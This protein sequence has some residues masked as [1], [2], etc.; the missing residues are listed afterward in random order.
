MSEARLAG[1]LNRGG[2]FLRLVTFGIP[3]VLGMFFH[4]LFNLVDLIIVGPLG[5]WALAGV[6]QAGIVN[7]IPMLI[8]TGV[9]NASIAY[10]SRNF[11]MRNYR[12]A[13]AYALQSFLL[14][15]VLAGALGWPSYAYAAE[16][17]RLVGSEG[18]ALGA[19]TTY[20]EIN[21]A[22]LVTMFVLMQV[23]AVLRAGGNARWP[24]ILLVGSNLL[25]VG[26][27]YAMVYGVWGFPRMEVAGAAWGTVIARGLF[28][29]LGLYIILLPGVPVRLILRR[30]WPRARM[31]GQLAGLGV[32][33]SLQ[34]VVRVCAYGA[35]LKLVNQF[36]ETEAVQ[37]ALAVGLRLDM[38]GIFTG[39]GWGAAAAAMVGQGLG[40]GFPG[41]AERAGWMASLLNV[42]LMAAIGVL[43]WWN[44]E[45]LVTFF[46]E[47]PGRDPQFAGT[48]R[49]GV[50]YLRIA[51]FG[52]P[53]AAVGITLAQSLNGAGSTK[54]P[55][56]LDAVG[57]LGLQVPVAGYIAHHHERLGLGRSAMWWSLVATTALAAAFYAYVWRRGH[58][59]HKRI[60]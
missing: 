34:F 33:S 16:L 51:V 10:M 13:N 60:S 1:D 6:N 45:W 2:L 25:N 15:L 21:S 58:W 5:P 18:A 4:S 30:P 29:L 22:G 49:L 9:N 27:S 55:L 19:A 23:T 11:G 39:A 3:L 46:G 43:Y 50:E 35:I 47:D 52:Y 36:G 31:I 8:S 17:N 12:R 38:L 24:M 54:T 14:L 56:L 48:V 20:L 7:F 53:F 40:G 44:A 28:A 32:P 37:S 59:K 26:L 42:L 41:R 57:F